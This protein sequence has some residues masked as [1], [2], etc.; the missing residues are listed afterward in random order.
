MRI[1][2]FAKVAKSTQSTKSTK[3]TKSAKF[4]VVSTMVAVL[5]GAAAPA[6]AHPAPPPPRSAPVI[7]MTRNL[8][9]GADLTSLVAADSPAAFATAVQQILA[10]VVA[11][12]PPQRMAWV[13]DEIGVAHADVVAL[14]EA[15]VWQ[16]Q[17]PA[18][19]LRF[20][21]VQLLLQALAAKGLHYTVAVRQTN[22]DSTKQ[23]AGVPLPASFADQ[24]AILVKEHAL[25]GRLRVLRTGAAHY[26]SQLANP[27]LLGPVDFD[28]GYVWAD[29]KTAGQVWRVV[30]THFEAYPGFGTMLHD[31]TADQAKELLATLPA[32]K[33]TV[34]LGDLNSSV[35]DPLAQGYTVLT[36]NGFGDAWTNR[37]PAAPG[38]TCCRS[39]DLSGDALTERIDYVLYRGAVRPLFSIRI[40]VA[41]RAQAAPRWASDHAGVVAVLAIGKWRSRH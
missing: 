13:A 16:I 15:A 39:A 20:D 12:N 3:S 35:T 2:T 21:F 26:V 38:L 29:V 32:R 17:T 14:Q 36:G 33:P 6:S 9:L 4:A 27:T 25:A 1:A 10:A 41:P 30:D 11:S 34:V 8:Y 7:V 40:G 37:H 19:T 31:Y 24:D 18:G 28:R 23:L 22:F 5:V